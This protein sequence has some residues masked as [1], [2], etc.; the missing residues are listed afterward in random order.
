MTGGKFGQRQKE[1]HVT[2]VAETGMLQLPA[3][4]GEGLLA[5]THTQGEEGKGGVFPGSFCVSPALM[6]S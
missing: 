4:E 1:E 2:R 6:T 5:T 3:T